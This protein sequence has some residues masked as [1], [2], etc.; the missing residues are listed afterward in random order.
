MLVYC[1]KVREQMSILKKNIWLGLIVDFISICFLCF[2]LFYSFFF[3]FFLDFLFIRWENGI[4]QMH[5][6]TETK[7][8]KSP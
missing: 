6:L 7:G 2:V 8:K 4:C 3:S 5:L 1:L